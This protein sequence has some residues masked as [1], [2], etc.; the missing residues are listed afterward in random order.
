MWIF[1]FYYVVTRLSSLTFNGWMAQTWKVH[2]DSSIVDFVD[3]KH[4][5][6]ICVCWKVP[7]TNKKSDQYNGTLVS[8]TLK[9]HRG[10][11]SL[12]SDCWTFKPWVPVWKLSNS[13]IIQSMGLSDCHWWFWFSPNPDA[14]CPSLHKCWLGGRV[15]WL[16][17]L[18]ADQ[19]AAPL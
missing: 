10:C 19:S 8:D 17:S 3:W 4:A 11:C 16:G 6:V 5:Q 15:V 12:P 7:W 13:Y 18:G 9:K 14:P 1:C 2:I